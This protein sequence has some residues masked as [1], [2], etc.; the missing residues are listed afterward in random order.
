MRLITVTVALVAVAVVAT[1]V[2]VGAG[3]VH[4]AAYHGHVL[5]YA[6]SSSIRLETPADRNG[7]GN[8][9]TFSVQG[10]TVIC[11]DGIETRDLGPYRFKFVTDR[12]FQGQ[13]YRSS[14][15]GQ[16]SYFEVKGEIRRG[17]RANGYLYYVEDSHGDP[18][19]GSD[20]NTGGQLYDHWSA[21]KERG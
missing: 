11:Q 15:D 5:G 17:G 9:A 16:W 3:G 13:K 4:K 10:L 21:R 19:S 14:N 2:A 7:G 18:A 6:K 12:L 1:Q 20:C 8:A